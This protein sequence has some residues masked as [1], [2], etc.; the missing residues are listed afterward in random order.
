MKNI[1]SPSYYNILCI[2]TSATLDQIKSSWRTLMKKFHPDL[3]PNNLQYAN[4]K[5]IEINAAYEVLSD[6]NQKEKY[7]ANLNAFLRQEAET[8][9]RK[10]DKSQQTQYNYK[11]SQNNSNQDSWFAVMML[12]MLLIRLLESLNSS[13]RKNKFY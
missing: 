1:Y 6:P 13:D 11:P 5:S 10:E 4:E 12:L 9:K 3:N 8:K 2:E 7:D